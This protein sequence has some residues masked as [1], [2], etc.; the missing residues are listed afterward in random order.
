MKFSFRRICALVATVSVIAIGANTAQAASNAFIHPGALHSQA[1]FA[2]MKTRIAEKAQPWT[3]DWDVLTRNP[4]AS[5]NWTPHPV[6]MLYRGAD[7][8]HP[9]NY[10]AL[11]ND[12][13][14]AYALALRWKISGDDAYADKA[15]AILDAWST[16][17]VGIGGTSDKF[18]ASGI[19]GYQLADVAEIM[20]GYQKWPAQ[21]VDRFKAMML[22][23]FYPMN[24][25]FLVRHN[26]AKI[27]HYWANWDLA[28]M[29]SMLAIGI[30]TDRRD[31][32][33][34]A[35]DYFKH[36]NGNG[37][38]DHVVWK[39]YPG[40]LGQTQES[41]RDQGHNTLNVALL[42]AFCQMAWNQHDDLFG[43]EDNRVLKGIEYIAKYNQGGDVPYT[44]Y[45]NSDVTQNVISSQGRGGERPVWELFYNHYVVLKG[46][47]APYLTM[48]AKVTRPEG[49]GG[50]YG[51]NSGGFDQLG[52]GTLT[53]TL[54]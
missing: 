53:Y 3:D 18:L 25:D 31:I 35:V 23:V 42:G 7:G 10:S 15:V 51:P 9:E 4:H 40:G 12:T 17:L 48:A 30:L 45:S 54:R 46:L 39:L 52:Y 50:N 41:G 34:E 19:Y 16:K 14:A 36:G 27:D 8:T 1:D 13:A 28:N 32:Y 21:N 43:Y 47:D 29:D 26:G 5:L 2:R 22:T 24:H 49:G 33:N 20:R 11:F 44:P 37:A 6:E 38:I